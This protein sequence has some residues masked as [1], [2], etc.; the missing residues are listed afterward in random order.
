MR[1]EEHLSDT[2]VIDVEVRNLLVQSL[3]ILICAEF[4]RKF[5][6]LTIARCSSV[7]DASV[8]SYI[9]K[10]T[11]RTFR[12]LRLHDVSNLL[13]Q[14]GPMHKDKFSQLRD[15]KADHMYSSI[16][17]NR[18]NV[19]HGRISNVTIGELKLY[20][21]EGHLVLDYFREALG[22]DLMVRT[23]ASMGDDSHG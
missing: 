3:L 16:V 18:N 7:S 4:E 22:V 9:E 14:F 19:A 15:D 21:E 1:C 11:E 20:Y 8:M 13:A 12:S 5:K 17:N 6:D 10:I 23:V 2:D